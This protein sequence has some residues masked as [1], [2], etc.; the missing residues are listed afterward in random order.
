MMAHEPVRDIMRRTM[1]NLEFSKRT[2]ESTVPTDSSALASLSQR[3]EPL[4]KALGTVATRNDA[5][6][7]L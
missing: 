5:F 6:D 1:Q 4:E 3:C 7:E 2:R